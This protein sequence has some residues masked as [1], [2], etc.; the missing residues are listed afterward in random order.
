MANSTMKIELNTGSGWQLLTGLIDGVQNFSVTLRNRAEDG[1][2]A[3][4]FS[5]E[6]TFYDE[7]YQILKSFL[8]DDPFGFGKTV[9]I[10][11]FDDCCGEPV[12]EG[13]IKGDAI[14]WCEPK[15]YV[16]ANVIEDDEKINCIKSTLITD[17]F[18]GIQ[19]RTHPRIRYC[20]EVRPD[21]FQYLLISL[22]AFVN[23][24]FYSVILGLWAGLAAIFGIVYIICLIVDAIPGVDAN[25]NSPLINPLTQLAVLTEFFKSWEALI[26]PCGRFHP[27]PYV[28]DYISNACKK[29]GL[30]FQSSILNNVSSPYYNTVLFAAQV[31]KGRA[32]DSTNDTLIQDNMPVETVETLMNQYLKPMFNAEFQIVNNVL[33]F[34]RKDYFF[35]T[36][37]WIDTE[38]LLNNSQVVNNEICFSWIDKERWAFGQFEY[39]KDAVDYIGN[40]AMTRFNDIVEWNSPYNPTQ[41]GSRDVMLLVSPS[42]H[43]D[44]G[45]DRTVY[46]HFQTFAGGIV[47]YIYFGL[48]SDF[49]KTLLM[50]QHTAFNYKFLIYDPSSGNDGIVKH[51]YSNAFCGG[52]PGAA[53]DERFNY[54][55]WFA[56]GY[57]N[58]LYSLFHYIDDPRL[59]GTTQFEF[60]FQFQFD[61]QTYN[62]FNFA[63]TIRLVKNGQIVNGV[64]KEIQVDFA[65]R[66][67]NVQGIV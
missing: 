37:T 15:C 45:I 62:D 14:D 41:S 57:Q 21:F 51:D 65:K 60:N 28:R 63:K 43:R 36:T 5:S 66:I 8:I 18:E 49:D 59:P 50:N 19:Q 25:C 56:G 12:F 38:Q 64:I 26:V 30:T 7:G 31:K 58:N 35:S 9:Q 46:D 1:K 55:F 39:T 13:L 27:S 42:R 33:V 44:D 52:D 20:I 4:S 10:R 47:N 48:F 61:C 22:A 6:L 67:I 29:C 16:S 53:P 54:P 40:E 23:I 3:K 24:L 17:N 32:Y 34:E 2:L 11:I